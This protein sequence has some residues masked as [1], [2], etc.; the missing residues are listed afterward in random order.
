MIGMNAN[1]DVRTGTV[2]T[3]M[4]RLGLRDLLLD[5]LLQGTTA[6]ETNIKSTKSMSIDAIFITPGLLAA[7][8]GFSNYNQVARS[9]HRVSW[10]DIP[11]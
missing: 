6:P 5:R 2:A 10:A 11:K 4:R 8:G 9:D 3:M 1:E 7:I